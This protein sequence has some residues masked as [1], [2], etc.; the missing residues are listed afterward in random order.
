MSRKHYIAIA[1]ALRQRRP[2]P[3]DTPLYSQWKGDVQAMAST[4]SEHNS[5]FDKLRF[6][7][8]A[9]ASE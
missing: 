8:R 6:L 9:G 2:N 3:Q 4:L 1:D 5:N 7:D